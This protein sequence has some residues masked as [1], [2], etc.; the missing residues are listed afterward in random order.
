MRT[1]DNGNGEKNDNRVIG[2]TTE[3]PTGVALARVSVTVLL[4]ALAIGLLVGFFC[5]GALWCV[6]QLQEQIWNHAVAA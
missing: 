4:L 6:D 5:I 3:P 1:G 2:A